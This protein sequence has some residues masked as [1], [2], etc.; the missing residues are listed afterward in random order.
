MRPR[1]RGSP[2][3]DCTSQT[4]LPFSSC[5]RVLD[6]SETYEVSRSGLDGRAEPCARPAQLPDRAR[7]ARAHAPRARRAPTSRVARRSARARALRRGRP[8][9][10]HRPA[11][12]RRSSRQCDPC[13]RRGARL[14]ADHLPPAGGP[15]GASPRRATGDR[16]RIV[17]AIVLVVVSIPWITAAVGVHFPQGLFLT[18]RAVRRARRGAHEPQSTSA[19]ITR[20]PGSSSLCRRCCSPGR[21][22]TGRR[23][24][25]CVSVLVCLMLAYGVANVVNDFWHEQVVKRGW[26]SWDVPEAT[27]P[28]AQ[29]HVGSRPRRHRRC[30]MP[31]GSRG[32]APRTRGCNR[33]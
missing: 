19:S 32:R 25:T 9:R 5:T 27:Q 29:P 1:A 13:G 30:S 15:A 18:E 10:R 6:P 17:V 2:S 26:T 24:R 3:G 28:G 8:A 7:R 22:L 16:A 20:R 31:A 12:S 33:R 23:L 14:R 21:C 4:S 11:R